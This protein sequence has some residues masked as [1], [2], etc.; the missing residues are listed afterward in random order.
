MP[1]PVQILPILTIAAALIGPTVI[2]SDFFFRA[3]PAQACRMM[4][5]V[6]PF[7]ESIEIAEYIKNHSVEGDKIA[8]IGSEPQLYFYSNRKSSTGYIYV[9]G[10]MEVQD[11]ASKM[12]TEMIHEIQ[13]ARPKYA[14]IVNVPTSWLQRPDSDRTIFRWAETYFSINYRIAG[15]VDIFPNGNSKVYW[16]EEARRNRPRSQFNVYVLERKEG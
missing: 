8:V 11:Y 1:F 10:L 14:V 15:F 7:P 16:D 2:L 12:Q 9:Y 4:Y 3:N 6:N 5:G 13:K